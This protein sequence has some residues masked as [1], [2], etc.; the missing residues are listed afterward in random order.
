MILDGHN[1]AWLLQYP[2]E[3]LAGGSLY[4]FHLPEHIP[5]AGS[6]G[7]P[8]LPSAFRQFAGAPIELRGFFLD[9]IHNP[10][11]LPKAMEEMQAR[12]RS[13]SKTEARPPK[14]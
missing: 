11:R 7:G 2:H 9:L 14:R 13:Q 4:A 3:P 10:E 8:P 12:F 1:C 5:E 6:P